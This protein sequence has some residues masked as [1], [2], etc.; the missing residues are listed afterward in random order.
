M[1]PN[2]LSQ[3][4]VVVLPTGGRPSEYLLAVPYDHTTVIWAPLLV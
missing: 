1:Q 4:L 3:N 2:D